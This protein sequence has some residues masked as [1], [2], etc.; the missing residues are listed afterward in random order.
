MASAH[1]QKANYEQARASM[2]LA[3]AQLQHYI[4]G[5][6]SNQ[7]LSSGER[8]TARDNTML[9]NMYA[10]RVA[11]ALKHSGCSW[12]PAQYTAMCGDDE[13]AIGMSWAAG[14]SYVLEHEQQG[15]SIQKR[16][17]MI[18]T[19][20][21]EFLQYNMQSGNI[22]CP[23]QP[24]APAL[25]NFVSGSWYKT[26]AY[27]VSDYPHQVSE[28]AASCIRRGAR[29]DTM[30]RMA[31]STCNWLCEGFP[32]RRSLL[33][34]N[35]FGSTNA[36]PLVDT[37]TRKDPK[38]LYTMTKPQGVGDYVD[39]INRRFRLTDEERHKVFSYAC[40]N[41]YASYMAD[42]RAK[43]TSSNQEDVPGPISWPKWIP[44]SNKLM[45]QWQTNAV[46][47]R[48][49]QNTWLAVQ[50]GLPLPLISRLTVQTIV[51]RASNEMRSHIDLQTPATQMMIDP[52]EMAALPGAVAPFFT[53]HN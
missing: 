32:W 18:S 9:H 12:R 23:T 26:A 17:I 6:L 19:G 37:T 8:D 49:D 13:I 16:K 34:T 40:D 30:C 38:I 44:P 10:K 53:T 27:Q 5:Q 1:N 2:W 46:V 25:N 11:F 35:L 15:H 47:E 22:K 42:T 45:Q 4:D 20:K 48:T 39:S 36:K 41:V 7:G 52:V 31:I 21:G 3:E 50:L 28:A 29:H 43:I 51:A 24:L 33:A 14:V